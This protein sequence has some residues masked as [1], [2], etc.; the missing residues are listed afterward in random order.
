MEEQIKKKLTL[1]EKIDQLGEKV[2]KLSEKTDR[3]DE[4]VDK[5]DERT[6]KLDEKTDRLD[7]KFDKKFSDL[8]TTVAE[9]SVTVSETSNTLM[10]FI[11]FVKDTVVTKDDAKKFATKED[12]KKL[13]TK[14]DLGSAVHE[15][16]LEMNGGFRLLEA[17]LADIKIC[18]TRLEKKVQED[19]D[20]SL[21]EI[22]KMWKRVKILE[23]DMVEVKQYT[24]EPARG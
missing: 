2:D 6:D 10:E 1:D 8:T 11:A 18:L 5:L 17:E 4:K 7:E 22:Q 20:V 21:L 23:K 14:D 3:L 12:L 16:K 19:D 13:A 15:L 24:K 9:L